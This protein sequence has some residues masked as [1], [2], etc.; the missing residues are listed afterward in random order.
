MAHHN[1]H[2]P[3]EIIANA[4]VDHALDASQAYA[5]DTVRAAKRLA[6]YSATT[7]REA[8]ALHRWANRVRVSEAILPYMEDVG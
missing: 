2:H 4:I 6:D 7:T 8:N 3:V 5:L 1:G